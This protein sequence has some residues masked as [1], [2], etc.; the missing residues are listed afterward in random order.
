MPTIK[1]VI[2]RPLEWQELV[3]TE[4]RRFNVVCIGR[5]AGKTTL[6]QILLTS[7]ET[8]SYPQAWFSPTYKDMLEP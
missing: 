7:P 2:P 4:A 8:L 5:R 6:G 3:R 1:L